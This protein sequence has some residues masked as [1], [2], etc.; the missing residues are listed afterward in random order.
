MPQWMQNI[1]VHHIVI[2]LIIVSSVG[3]WLLKVIGEQAEK[4]KAEQTRKQRE[5]DMLRSGNVG[6]GTIAPSPTIP[7]PV[8]AQSQ[9]LDPRRM[10]EEIAAKR[11]QQLDELRARQAAQRQ[12]GVPNPAQDRRAKRPRPQAEARP[13]R[14][15]ALPPVQPGQL[16]PEDYNRAKR[17]E[18]DE[19]ARRSAVQAAQADARREDRAAEVVRE[20]ARQA[21]DADNR[22]SADESAQKTA[23]AF[24]LPNPA[25]HVRRGPTAVPQS[26]IRPA[27][28]PSG[29][30]GG[31]VFF[32]G[33]PIGSRAEWRRLM[34]IQAVLGPCVA[35]QDITGA[36]DPTRS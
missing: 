9:Q 32:P 3:Q 22:R 35:Q 31:A 36:S 17:R 6:G 28:R 27:G 18:A 26:P 23:D 5:L 16:S 20:K 25:A 19:R 10:L 14:A 13:Q 30:A 8:Q 4:R 21:R 2:F 7:Q 15:S 29:S 24:A 34:A 11:Q 33:G 1:S 12:A